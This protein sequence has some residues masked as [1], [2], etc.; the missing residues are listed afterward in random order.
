MGKFVQPP[1]KAP[2]TND[3]T[4]VLHPT[5]QRHMVAVTDRLTQPNVPV[6]TVPPVLGQPGDVR[7]DA[8]FIYVCVAKDTWKK[9]AIV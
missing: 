4:G 2:V 1:L 6:V 8:N 7:I 5:W 3:E 9:A